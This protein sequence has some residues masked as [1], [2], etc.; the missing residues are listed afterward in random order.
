M[1]FPHLKGLSAL[2][3]PLKA[4]APNSVPPNSAASRRSACRRGMPSASALVKS[5]NRFCM[6]FSFREKK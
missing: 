2:A 6:R 5:S 1:F 3:L 4:I